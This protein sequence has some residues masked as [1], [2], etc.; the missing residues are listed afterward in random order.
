MQGMFRFNYQIGYIMSDFSKKI[1]ACR[2]AKNCSQA[3]LARQM[4]VHHSL[5]GKYERDE[6]RPNIDIVQRMASVLDTTVGYLIGE[7]N[8]KDILK[9]PTMLKRLNDLLDLPQKDRDYI[10][11]ALDGLLRDA[12]ARQAYAS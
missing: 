1:R 5:I 2:E 12:K 8:D 11:Y 9:D 3:E 7:S 4:G 10:L 6:V